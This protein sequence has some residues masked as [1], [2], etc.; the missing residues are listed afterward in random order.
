MTNRDNKL[1]KAH[2]SV[3]RFT[4]ELDKK[5]KDPKQKY[6]SSLMF[7]H[8]NMTDEKRKDKNFLIVMNKFLTYH[9]FLINDLED[10]ILLAEK[11]TETYATDELARNEIAGEIEDFLYNASKSIAL[12]ERTIKNEVI[13][14]IK[15]YRDSSPDTD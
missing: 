2:N 1:Q 14:S 4:N 8:E 6:A 7:D 5:Y 10:S 13:P 3:L 12:Y 15:K 11:I 9:K